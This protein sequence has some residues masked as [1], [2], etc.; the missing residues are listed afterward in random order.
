VQ[1]AQQL[2]AAARSQGSL[3]AL[4]PLLPAAREL[5]DA[6]AARARTLERQQLADVAW[7]LAHLDS[8]ERRAGAGAPS[9]SDSGSGSAA[10]QGDAS[11]AASSATTASSSAAA[12]SSATTTPSSSGMRLAVPWSSALHAAMGVPF[13]VLPLFQP[14]L[15]LDALL[16]EVALNRDLIQLRPGEAAVPESRLTGWQS[17]IGASFCY[18]GKEMQAQA[19]GMTRR[20]AEVRGRSAPGGREGW[21]MSHVQWPCWRGRQGGCDVVACRQVR[22]CL[23]GGAVR[24]CIGGW[25][26]ALRCPAAETVRMGLPRLQLRDLLH[27]ATG[28]W[29][30]S[31]LIN[32]YP[33]GKCGMRYHAGERRAAQGRRQ[34]GAGWEVASRLLAKAARSPAAPSPGAG[35]RV[36]RRQ[37][38]VG[39]LHIPWPHVHGQSAAA[40][41]CH[42]DVPL[43]SLGAPH[44]RGPRPAQTR[45]TAAGRHTPQSYPWATPDA[46]C[47]ERRPTTP[48]AGSTP[49]ATATPWSCMATARTGCSMPS[50]W[51][52]LPPTPAPG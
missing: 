23:G 41:A 2:A 49:S 16:A 52:R 4:Q 17:D 25:L 18:S 51:R 38:G 27:A 20:V 33:D 6:A 15:S 11:T 40:A 1:L 12:A 19:G 5:R 47:S 50:W 39:R 45:C 42:L 36:T 22:A 8:L 35:S 32:L 3:Q 30:D 44:H 37:Q 46:S 26:A 21:A 9:T 14:A 31:V 13:Q 48:V 34:G 7:C 43:A 29:Y 28:V 24:W 10:T